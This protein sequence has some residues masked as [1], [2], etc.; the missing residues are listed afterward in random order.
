[1]PCYT[2]VKTALR[3]AAGLGQQF[4]H[5]VDDRLRPAGGDQVIA[6]R[7]HAPGAVRGTLRQMLMP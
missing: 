4:E 3:S 2:D 1:M 5:G 7:H 6:A